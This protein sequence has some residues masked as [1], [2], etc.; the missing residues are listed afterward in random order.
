MRKVFAIAAK[1]WIHTF[2][3]PVAYIVLTVMVTVFNVFFF[4]IVDQNQEAV[5]RDIFQVME[6]LFIF[7]IPLLTMKSLAEEK[8]SGTMEFLLTTTTSETQIVVGKY[9]GNVALLTFVIGLTGIYAGILGIF[10]PPDP[11]PL[12]TGYAGIW[13]EAAFFTAVGIFASSLTVS[14]VAA[15]MISYAVLFFLYFSV[16]GE[17]YVA[18][19]SKTFLQHISASGHLGNF[20]AGVLAL[21]DAVYY[22]SGIIFFLGMAIWMLKKR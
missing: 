14:Q 13:L 8:S 10:S 6:F 16:T 1:E 3:S 2:R 11:L 12:V 22:V 7:I 5:L 15:A 20:S 4:L 17:K 19:I 18:G 21:S 9:L